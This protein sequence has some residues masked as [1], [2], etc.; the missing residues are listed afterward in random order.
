MWRR[1]SDTNSGKYIALLISRM[2]LIYR[3]EYAIHI[4]NKKG[5]TLC[6]P[7]VLE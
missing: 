4:L 2:E 1:L 6:G 3:V 5:K 7:T